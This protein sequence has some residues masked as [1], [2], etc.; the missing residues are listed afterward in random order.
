MCVVF[1]YICVYVYEIDYAIPPPL[2]TIGY[3]P[4]GCFFSNHDTCFTRSLTIAALSLTSLIAHQTFKMLTVA[5]GRAV[6]AYYIVQYMM[7]SNNDMLPG[8]KQQQHEE[9]IRSLVASLVESY[10]HM[11]GCSPQTNPRAFF[12]IC[13]VLLRATTTTTIS[14]AG[15]VDS[16][17]HDMQSHAQATALQNILRAALQTIHDPDYQAK[18][19]M[20]L[21]SF[22]GF[23]DDEQSVLQ[24]QQCQPSSTTT[25]SS[26]S[27]SILNHSSENE[28]QEEEHLLFNLSVQ[29]SRYQND[30]VEIGM[31]GRGGFASVWRARNKLDGIEYAI[32][33]IRLARRNPTIFREIKHLARLE[34]RNIVRY[35]SSWL[36]V[37]SSTV[38]EQDEED[39]IGHPPPPPP[40]AVI[41]NQSNR[42]STTSLWM[43]NMPDMLSDMTLDTTPSTSSPIQFGHHDNSSTSTT[44]STI[45]SSSSSVNKECSSPKS[46]AQQR[47]HHQEWTL[48]IQMQL[49]PCKEKQ[50]YIYIF[51]NER[52]INYMHNYSNTA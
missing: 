40:A 51:M 16:V 8:N 45:S 42:D 31:L 48:Y 35:Y 39:D 23:H 41:N 34:H 14:P 5:R 18:M 43:N 28:E 12:L 11:H 21:S 4:F 3:P 38:H 6:Y 10:H 27:C 15:F 52:V 33:K 25:S 13:Q 47:H 44:T 20:A 50:G 17:Y 30:F 26:P 29:N 32:K 49:C 24:Q 2:I 46:H 9:Q 37:T 1:V 19:M 22:S 7:F 36:Q